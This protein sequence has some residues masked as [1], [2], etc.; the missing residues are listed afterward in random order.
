MSDEQEAAEPDTS[1]VVT[2]GKALSEEELR[3]VVPGDKLSEEELRAALRRGALSRAEMQAVM[4]GWRRLAQS[5]TP[6][7]WV[8]RMAADPA[9]PT[10]PRD[11]PRRERRYLVLKYLLHRMA[12][13]KKMIFVIKFVIAPLI[14]LAV[15]V[16]VR[17]Y[18]YGNKVADVK[19]DA[20]IV[21]GAAVWGDEVSPVFRERI[22]HAIDLYRSG[23]VRKLIFTGGQ[24]NRRELTEA[25]AAR[26]YAIKNGVPADDILIEDR[27][28]TTYENVI[29]AKQLADANG[30]RKVLIV[31]D[32]LHMKRAV[33]MARDV[34]LDAYPSPT[35]TTRYQGWR[36][37]IESL[38]H[39]TYYYTGY[40]AWK[41]FNYE[42]PVSE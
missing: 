36:S 7:G 19:A 30:L 4:R 18:T 22:N 42:L 26:A 3:A 12:L 27:S 2:D 33:T 39:E 10:F 32:P 25:A 17:I 24:G 16:A 13:R 15:L 23:K 28:H 31:S 34:G 29:N 5:K 38:A 14:L 37:Q 11:A 41:V 40:W 8:A 21:L 20:A 1:K 35:P 6:A 9:F